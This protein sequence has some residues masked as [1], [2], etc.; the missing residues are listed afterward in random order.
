MTRR[1][2][3]AVAAMLLAGTL[4]G[5][6][7][8]DKQ[9]ATTSPV[10]EETYV[11]VPAAQVNAGLTGTQAAIDALAAAPATATTTAVDTVNKSW[12]VYEGNVRIADAQAYLDAEDALARFADAAK[13]ADAAGLKSA[14]DMFRAMSTA[15]TTAH[16]G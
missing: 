15:Y 5:A 1:L 10:T 4:L 3:G 2:G 13:K 11:T 6:C 12:L 7:G 16:P 9:A 8:S 14:A